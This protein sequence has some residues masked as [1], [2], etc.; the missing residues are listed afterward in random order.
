M[1]EQTLSHINSSRLNELLQQFYEAT[2]LT[3]ADKAQKL[4]SQLD[5]MADSVQG[6]QEIYQFI[7]KLT[8][9]GI[10]HA[11]R[12]ENVLLEILAEP[13]AREALYRNAEHVG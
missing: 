1:S 8:E 7:P 13:H 4:M 6:I 9:A 10:F 5:M 11:E 3:K 2:P 12:R